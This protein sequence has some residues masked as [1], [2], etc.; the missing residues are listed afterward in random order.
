VYLYKVDC[1]LYL[2]GLTDTHYQP[3]TYHDDQKLFSPSLSYI[4]KDRPIPISHSDLI[5][6]ICPFRKALTEAWMSKGH[7][8]TEDVHNDMI[9]GLWK[10]VNSIYDGKQSSSWLY[11]VGKSNITVLGK[12]NSK[13]LIIE[14]G[15]TVGV[16]VICEDG[17]EE[18]YKAKT[19]VI[20]SSGIFETPKLLLLL[21]IGPRR[22]SS[23]LGSIRSSTRRTSGRTCS[24]TPFSRMC[25]ASKTVTG[26]DHHLLCAGLEK[27]AAILLY[28]WKNTGPY[29]SGLLE[30]V[31]LPRIDDCLQGIPEYKVAKEANGGK[32]LFGP[33]GS[34]LY[35][36]L[37]LGQALTTMCTGQPHFEINFVPMFSDMFQWHIPTPPSGDYFVGGAF[38]SH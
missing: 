38:N 21:G 34:T 27:D 11:L 3:A 14:N 26:L 37:T 16:V 29:T 28:H 6:E 18:S 8:L 30:L 12:T 13:E 24:T 2:L 7:P 1:A 17:T 10:S 25:S 31:G 22:R 9:G 19:E 4:G 36:L 33:A 15:H 5:L 35:F 23:S 20:V 32:D